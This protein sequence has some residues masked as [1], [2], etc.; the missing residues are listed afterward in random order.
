MG[1]L[2]DTPICFRSVYICCFDLYR[3]SKEANVPG[4]YFLVG[5]FG[6]PVVMQSIQQGGRVNAFKNFKIELEI[7]LRKTVI[8]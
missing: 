7:C 3:T 8:K 2:V 6:V 5:G 4:I 1:M